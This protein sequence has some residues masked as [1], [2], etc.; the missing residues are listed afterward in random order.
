VH[1]AI[2]RSERRRDRYDRRLATAQ[3]LPISVATINF[4]CDENLGY[5][6][7][8]AACFGCTEVHVV[9]K[10]PERNF[11]KSASGSL[12][13]YVDLIQHSNPHD[14]IEYMRNEQT[15]LVSAELHEKSVLL[16]DYQ[17]NFDSRTCIVLGNENWG[18]P[19]EIIHNSDVVMIPMPGVGSCLNTAQTG[20]IILYEYTRRYAT[21]MRNREYLCAV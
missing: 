11:L 14:L 15:Q 5:I 10:I 16:D 8:A 19:E 17:F 9:G 6:I 12:V 7:R 4:G 18:V 20:N 2:L 21:Q 13:D 3:K 1:S